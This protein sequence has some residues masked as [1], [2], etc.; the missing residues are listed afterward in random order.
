MEAILSRIL[1]MLM[2]D[3]TLGMKMN[4][5]YQRHAMGLG[6]LLLQCFTFIQVLLLHLALLSLENGMECRMGEP[7]GRAPGNGSELERWSW[8][9]RGL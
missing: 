4:I 9:D 1:S 3:S 6:F 7:T 8:V 5:T 2:N